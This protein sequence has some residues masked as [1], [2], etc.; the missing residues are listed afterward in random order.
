M[1]SSLA[2]TD[3]ALRQAAGRVGVPLFGA[4]D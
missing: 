3:A 2:T 1:D 4:L